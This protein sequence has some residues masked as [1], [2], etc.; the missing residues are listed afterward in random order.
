MSESD[1]IFHIE[2]KEDVEISKNVS[3]LNMILEGFVQFDVIQIND[4]TTYLKIKVDK[5]IVKRKSRN[6]G[7]KVQHPQEMYTYRQVKEMLSELTKDEVAKKLGYS[8]ATFYRRLKSLNYM[9]D[10]SGC[11]DHYFF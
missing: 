9:E 6:A 4:K 3:Q 2:I 5:D 11:E 1:S 7:R 10:I 8:R